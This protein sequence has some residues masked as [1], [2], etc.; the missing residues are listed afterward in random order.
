LF[1]SSLY[2]FVKWAD[3]GGAIGGGH[4]GHNVVELKKNKNK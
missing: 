2:L 4:V 1:I 3:L